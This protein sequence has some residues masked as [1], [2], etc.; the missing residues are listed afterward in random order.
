LGLDL[1]FV[2]GW[3]K[4][5]VDGGESLPQ[6]VDALR[7]LEGLA[8]TSGSFGGLGASRL[9]LVF[10]LVASFLQIAGQVLQARQEPER[11]IVPQLVTGKGRSGPGNTTEAE[12]GGRL[13][14]VFGERRQYLETAQLAHRHG[15]TLP[16]RE[17]SLDL[18][19]VSL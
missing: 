4:R 3:D 18:Q 11:R 5:S 9:R 12:A 7:T 8:D 17:L 6:R 15:P 10:G 16:D 1:G 2:R 13:R 19:H 14:A